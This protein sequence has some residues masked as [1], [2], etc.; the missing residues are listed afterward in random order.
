MP[1]HWC[2]CQCSRE[3]AENFRTQ[4]LLNKVAGNV[5][6]APPVR[7]L[8]SV[9]FLYL[10]H[11]DIY[12]LCLTRNNANVTMAF[13]FMASVRPGRGLGRNVVWT[14]D[15]KCHMNEY[16]TFNTAHSMWLL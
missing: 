2:A 7:T 4:I 9:T 6:S 8:G 5:G 11:A 13:Q 3:I 16:S 15:I 12:M 10:R 14:G 1:P